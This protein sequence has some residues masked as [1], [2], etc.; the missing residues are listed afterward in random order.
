MDVGTLSFKTALLCIKER[1]L[2]VWYT[3]AH[4]GE[5]KIKGGKGT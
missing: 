4:Q 2:G 5:R 3:D 1:K